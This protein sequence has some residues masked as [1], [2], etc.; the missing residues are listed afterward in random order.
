VDDEYVIER[1]LTAAYGAVLRAGDATVTE[2][3]AEAVWRSF[4]V[5]GP[6][7]LNALIRD[8]AR[9][10]LETA[11]EAS[12]LPTGAR[13]EEFRPPTKALGQLS[14]PPKRRWHRSRN[15]MICPI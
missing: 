12:V 2:P 1:V 8:H 11:L 10:I 13:P 5:P 14:T 15:A 6:L 4:F 3:A 7:P 9:L